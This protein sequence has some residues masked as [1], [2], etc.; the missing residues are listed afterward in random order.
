MITNIKA[1]REKSGKLQKEC[2]EYLGITLRAW[3]GYE[4]GIR[5]PRFE[6]FCKI[7]DMF[8]VTTDYLFGRETGKPE[9]IDQLASEFSMTE[10]EKKLLIKYLSLPE[11]V[12]NEIM[13]ICYNSVKEVQEEK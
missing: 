9:T 7:A 5:E 13:K 10:L 8:N 12:R 2:A 4:Q 3:Q 1:V 6:L 11:N